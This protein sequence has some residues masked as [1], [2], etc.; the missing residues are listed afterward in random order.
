LAYIVVISPMVSVRL[1]AKSN[2][3]TAT[4]VLITRPMRNSSR[5]DIHLYLL[6]N[7]SD[8]ASLFYR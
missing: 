8:I 4:Q 5:N 3:N 6:I 2:A 1:E 7:Y